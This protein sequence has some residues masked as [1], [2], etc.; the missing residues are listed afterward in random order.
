MK[1]LFIDKIHPYLQDVLEQNNFICH[2]AY[3][4]DKNEIIKII[5]QYEGLIIR[6]RI[7]IDKNLIS[8]AKN[9]KFIARAGS[10]LE[11]IDI[12]HANYKNILCINAGEGN[13]QAV[14]EYAIGMILSLLNNINISHSE[15]SNGQWNREK[16]RG[17]ELSGKT[18]AIIGY[19]NTGSAFADNLKGFGV[20]ILCYDKYLKSYPNQSTMEKIYTDADIISLHVPLNEETQYIV[21]RSFIEK[22]EKNIFLINTSRGKCVNTKDLVVKIK[23]NK[24][25]GACLDVL[26]YEKSSF[27]QLSESKDD[28]DLRFLLNSENVVLSPHIALKVHYPVSIS[29]PFHRH[30]VCIPIYPDGLLDKHSHVLDKYVEL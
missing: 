10:G 8:Y 24:V 12:A 26:E 21:N 14:A 23:E 9:L 28:Q 18:V 29:L 19:G 15:V 4:K 3:D 27:E 16:N 7:Q 5:S 2:E 13:K 22:F 11:N 17:I 30:L 6:S 1:V 25:I 20:N